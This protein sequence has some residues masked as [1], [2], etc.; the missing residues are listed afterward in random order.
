MSSYK[1][2]RLVHNGLKIIDCYKNPDDQILN[3]RSPNCPL[4][5]LKY[6]VATVERNKILD[7][8]LSSAV[9][10]VSTA[11]AGTVWW[12]T[13][14]TVTAAPSPTARATPAAAQSHAGS[15]LTLSAHLVPAA[16]TAW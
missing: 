13:G 11:C 1:F 7:M 8:F 9:S 12:M 14:R 16:T 4:D 5:F 15:R 3:I 2:S 10:L 6:K